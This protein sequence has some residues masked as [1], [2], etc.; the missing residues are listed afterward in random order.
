[1]GQE[2]VKRANRDLKDGLFTA[3]HAISNDHCWVK[4]LRWV[5][6]HKNISYHTTI[7]MSPYETLYNKK[8]SLG[9]AHFGV[10][11]EH[12]NQINTE[13]DLS[14]YQNE[15]N[16]NTICEDSEI[17]TDSIPTSYNEFL[18]S[19]LSKFP[20]STDFYHDEIAQPIL[21][22]TILAEDLDYCHPI[23]SSTCLIPD[24]PVDTTI[25]YHRNL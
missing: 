23:Q 5:Q 10:P 1:M 2:A 17:S 13:Q 24:L 19:P 12:W 20:P 14:D 9:L 18:S 7:R 25:R 15:I 4:Y 22:G 11:H 16:E 21:H 3:M 8:L 6:L